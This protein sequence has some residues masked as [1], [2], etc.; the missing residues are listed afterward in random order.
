MYI[1]W[2][3]KCSLG[4]LVIGESNPAALFPKRPLE[5]ILWQYGSRAIIQVRVGLNDAQDAVSDE[6][7]CCR[8]IMWCMRYAII[9]FILKHWHQKSRSIT[10]HSRIL[11]KARSISDI[12]LGY[13]IFHD[14]MRNFFCIFFA[15]T[16]TNDTL[17]SW[18]CF[19]KLEIMH[20]SLRSCGAALQ[21]QHTR[22]P[23]A[24]V[25]V[26]AVPCCTCGAKC[27]F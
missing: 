15:E 3:P 9:A 13:P 20:G 24:S 1:N 5:K 12:H 26:R 6:Q 18:V 14:Q 4:S 11:Q 17:I 2:A 19:Y 10:T 8:M 22:A 25:S 23:D 21:L 7:S 27:F 16:C